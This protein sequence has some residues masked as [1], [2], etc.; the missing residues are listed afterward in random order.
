MFVFFF[1]KFIRLKFAKIKQF[2]FYLLMLAICCAIVYTI[3]THFYDH[4]KSLEIKL[5]KL[6]NE[7]GPRPIQSDN[8][9]NVDNGHHKTLN[10]I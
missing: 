2:I 1:F 4:Q 5:T 6:Q 7:N 3:F 8:K 9:Q 10:A